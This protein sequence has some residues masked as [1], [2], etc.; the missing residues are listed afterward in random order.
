MFIARL[1]LAAI[2]LASCISKFMFFDQTSEYMAS[3]GFVAVPLFLVAAAVV[4]FI[5]GLSLVFGF[6]IRLGATLLLLYLIPTTGIFHDFWNLTGAEQ[7]LQQIMFL[8]N[9]AIFGGLLYVLCFGAGILS[10]DACCNRRRSQ[11]G[12]EPIATPKPANDVTPQP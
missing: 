3:K 8:K 4:E 1:C 11:E 2:F 10:C 6:K 12:Q 5:G 7:Q 9:L